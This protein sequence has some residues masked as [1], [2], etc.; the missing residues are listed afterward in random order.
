M[1]AQAFCKRCG[2]LLTADESIE[3][4][5][6][7]ICWKKLKV[8]ELETEIN[9]ARAYDREHSYKEEIQAL[10]QEVKQLRATVHAMQANSNGNPPSAPSNDSNGPKI[11]LMVFPWDEKEL[12]TSELFE[13]ARIAAETGKGWITKERT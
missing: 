13:K 6:G 5:Y 11:P 2:R 7:P 1:A 3:R 8:Q 10:R 12:E 9:A 4:G